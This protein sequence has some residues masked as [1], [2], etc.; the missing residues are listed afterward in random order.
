[1]ADTSVARCYLRDA[2]VANGYEQP[3]N[4]ARIVVLVA[5]ALPVFGGLYYALLDF[6]L[7]G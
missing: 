1:M 2:G 4:W 3:V 6:L 7:F 5:M